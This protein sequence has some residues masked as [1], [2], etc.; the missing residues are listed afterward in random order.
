MRDD[1]TFDRTAGNLVL[2]F[3]NTVSERVTAPVE[4]LT[5]YD[6]LLAFGRQTGLLPEADARRLAAEARREPAKAARAL[7]DA[8]ELR[9][10]AFHAFAAVSEGRPPDRRDLDV[11]SDRHARLRL[12]PDLT[13]RAA[14]GP[15]SPDGFLAPVVRGAVDLLTSERRER[16]KRCANE[17]CPYGRWCPGAG[18]GRS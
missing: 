17:T 15:H 12:D 13:W 2:D 11:I 16:V 5:G 3:A 10:A 7:R 1:F 18:R 6:R 9:E 14:A 8:V 4:R